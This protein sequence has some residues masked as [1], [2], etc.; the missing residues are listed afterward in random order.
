MKKSLPIAIKIVA[1]YAFSA[2][3]GAVLAHDGHAMVG[4]HWHATDAMGFVALVC[5]VGV[6]VWMSGGKK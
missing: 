1:A 2:G 4:S 5:A 6:A 3:A